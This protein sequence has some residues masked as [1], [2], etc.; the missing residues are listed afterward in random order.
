MGSGFL[1]FMAIIGSTLGGYL[2]TLF[3][4]GIFSG[5]DILSGLVGGILFIW[6]G[7]KLTNS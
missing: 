2:P 3:G 1:V 7:Y 5:W 6:I 4:V